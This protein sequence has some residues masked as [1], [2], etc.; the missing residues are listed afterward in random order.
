MVTVSEAWKDV[1][2][3]F[4][5]PES[6]IEIECGITDDEAQSL[7]VARGMNEAAFSSVSSVLNSF[8]PVTK[9]ATLEHNLWSLDGSQTILPASGTYNNAGYVSDNAS[10]GRV[11]LS[12]PAVRTSAISGVSIT[13]SD[14]FNEYARVF[15]VIGKNGDQIVSEVTVTDNKSKVSTVT[16]PM[17]NYDSIV[18]QVHEWSLPNRR[19]RMEKL[20]IGLL[21]KF[22]K[23][24]LLDFSH[25]Q[26]GDLLSGKLPKYSIEFTLDNSD[27]K[28]DPNNPTGMAQYLSER[29]KLTVRYGLN[30]DGTT[31]WINA[32]TFYLSEW[33]APPNGLEAR[34]VARDVFDFLINEKYTLNKGRTL[35]GVTE[36]TLEEVITDVLASVDLPD[37]FEYHLEG[38]MLSNYKPTIEETAEYT[39]AE[40]IQMCANMACNYIRFD[41][42]GKMYIEDFIKPFP[43][44]PIGYTITSALSYAHPEVQLSKPL[45]NI[46]VD[47]GD[48]TYVLEIS[49]TGE[50]QTV[51]NPILRDLNYA[52]DIAN[53]VKYVLES[54]RTVSGEY[55]ADPRL[56]LYD[57]VAV[58]SKYGVISPVLITN[59]R[60]NYNGY[61]R[62]TYTGKVVSFGEV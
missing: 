57:I 26:D 11:E 59:I 53:G 49:P 6:F 20:A 5:L 44:M 45:K 3:R 13:W 30:V 39:C 40:M 58:E 16:A 29:Q 47:Y 4:L 61:F 17:E 22:D 38:G 21:L 8:A 60:Y 15:S 36:P 37:N 55:R 23:S 43:L 51:S 34:F 54:R 33:Y 42:E 14:S 10:G 32:G 24:D 31:E 12:F 48:G 27:G 50:T 19:V 7:A 35:T 18:I 25:E 28:W 2:Q 41:R 62:G 1:Q 9:Y 56:D 46:S 52:E